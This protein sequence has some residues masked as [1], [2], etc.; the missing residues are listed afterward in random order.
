MSYKQINFD[1]ENSPSD[2]RK[3]DCTTEKNNEGE[4]VVNC[5]PSKDEIES[6]RAENRGIMNF[7]ISFVAMCSAI[8]AGTIVS[9]IAFL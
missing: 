2:E 9:T 7:A 4:E 1:E 3:M 8:I 6:I 5:E